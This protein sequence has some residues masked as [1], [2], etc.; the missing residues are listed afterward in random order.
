MALLIA[1]I[2]GIRGRAG[3]S[4]G[5]FWQRLTRTLLYS[6]AALHP[7]APSLLVSQGVIQTP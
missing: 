5:N 4:L 7:S 6:A 1:V 3:R 2:R